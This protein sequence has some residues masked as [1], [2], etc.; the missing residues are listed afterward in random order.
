MTTQALTPERVSRWIRIPASYDDATQ[1]E[2][3]ERLI[4]ADPDL[5]T[6]WAI[7]GFSRD[8]IPDDQLGVALRFAG[9]LRLEVEGYDDSVDRSRLLGQ[10]AQRLSAKYGVVDWQVEKVDGVE[11]G[12]VGLPIVHLTA[13]EANPIPDIQETVEPD[14]MSER[15]LP[16]YAKRLSDRGRALIDAD[17]ERQVVTS[18]HLTPWDFW[19]REKLAASLSCAPWHLDVVTRWTTPRGED[20]HPLTVEIRRSPVIADPLMRQKRWQSIINDVL[21]VSPGASW[22][23]ISDGSAGG[24]VTFSRADDPLAVGFTLAEFESTYRAGGHDPLE[25]WKAFPIAVRENGEAVVYT[26]FHTLIVGQTGAGKGSVIWSVLSGLI[27]AAREGLVEMAMIDPKSA[28]GRVGVGPASRNNAVFSEI[29]TDPDAWA[30]LLERWVADLKERQ[31][32]AGRSAAI[33]RDCPLRVLVIDELSALMVLDTDRK[34]AG[35]VQA[36]LLTLLSQGRSANFLVIAAVQAPQKDMVGKA[37]M[38]LGM[39]IALR[40][41]TGIETDLTLG[42]GSTLQGAAAHLIEPANLGNGYKTAGIGYMRIEGESAPLRIRFPYTTDDD[43]EAWSDEFEGIRSHQATAP[44]VL[45]EFEMTLSLEE[46]DDVTA[47]VPSPQVE[48]PDDDG[49]TYDEDDEPLRDEDV[50]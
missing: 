25:S 40:T 45:N 2:E 4:A 47:P 37:R 16:D 27:P 5:G 44:T 49:W 46:L 23:M 22:R 21:P 24:P 48:E 10:A 20:A 17:V 39:R 26:L 34:R 9:G 42:D 6:G 14:L 11:P 19:L 1:R 38:F 15:N 18:A 29:A 28:E 30:D 36:N 31:R 33:T 12:A 3:L 50:L 41:E 32:T 43:L 35:E 13:G 7:V 8:G